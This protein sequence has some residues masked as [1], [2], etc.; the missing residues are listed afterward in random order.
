MKKLLCL[1]VVLAGAAAYSN[2]IAEAYP[3]VLAL[4]SSVGTFK[5][6]AYFALSTFCLSTMVVLRKQ[7]RLP[8][9]FFLIVLGGFFL[10]VA[11]RSPSPSAE[12]NAAI[13]FTCFVAGYLIVRFQSRRILIEVKEPL[14]RAH[15]AEAIARLVEDSTPTAPRLV[16]VPEL[17]LQ[18]S[19]LQLFTQ[20]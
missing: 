7:G 17:P 8:F 14:T 20:N 4:V 18:E 12:L 6:F 11:S 3:A 1:V 5:A 19:Q 2:I 9:G 16:V 15:K 13:G 10:G